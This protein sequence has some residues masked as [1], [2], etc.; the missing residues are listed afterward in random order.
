MNPVEQHPHTETK[1]IVRIGFAV[2]AAMILGFLLWA[3]FATLESAALARGEVIPAGKI[4]TVQHLDGG[5]ITEI[6]VKDGDRVVKG[7]E[8][9]RLDESEIRASLTILEKEEESLRALSDR[10]TSE[11]DG[12]QAPSRFS[13]SLAETVQGQLRLFEGRREALVKALEIGKQRIRQ[14]EEEIG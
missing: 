2:S 8:L 3:S 14:S 1:K 4:K 7:Q 6:L 12:R 5:I 11:R 13:S 9:I 10:L